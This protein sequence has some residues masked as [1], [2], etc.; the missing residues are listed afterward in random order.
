MEALI[1][2]F[3]FLSD[4]A[5]HDKNFDPSTIDDLMKLFE[6]ESYKSLAAMELEHETEVAEAE[7]SMK[8]AEDYLESAMES[9]M[10]EFRRFEE[11]MEAESNK[12][13]H[14][15]L[16]IRESAKMNTSF[17]KTQN[18]IE[19]EDLAHS[20]VLC[21]SLKASSVGRRRSPCLMSIES[22]K[23][24]EAVSRLLAIEALE[25]SEKMAIRYR[26][27]LP[28]GDV[29]DVEPRSVSPDFLLL[30]IRKLQCVSV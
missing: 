20:K 28:S 26:L 12:E 25:T 10:E 7:D 27:S 19:S 3:T 16:S 17:K 11:E 9:A 14:G 2:Q 5:L 15:L 18:K 6:L 1:S 4:Q 23:R 24:H 8:E 22:V 29:V 13:L 21:K 30:S